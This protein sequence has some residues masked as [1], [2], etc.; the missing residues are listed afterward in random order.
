[1][2]TKSRERGYAEHHRTDDQ[3]SD[4][5]SS[6]YRKQRNEGRTEHRLEQFQE[7]LND[8]AAKGGNDTDFKMKVAEDFR[9]EKNVL[10]HPK[11]E[12]LKYMQTYVEAFNEV[13]HANFRERAK[14]AK[15]I[16]QN[17]FKPIYQE[18]EALEADNA[19]KIPE[20][21]KKLFKKEGITEF[22]YNEET[23]SIEFDFK[24]LKQLERVSKRSGREVK[25]LTTRDEST[26]SYSRETRGHQEDPEDDRNK[27]AAEHGTASLSEE[28]DQSLSDDKRRRRIETSMNDFKEGL[29]WSNQ[30]PE[31]NAE[32]MNNALD[33]ASQYANMP[34]REMDE[35][36]SFDAV[37]DQNEEQLEA[38]V[39]DKVQQNWSKIH[40]EID[41]TA[42]HNPEE[43]ESLRAMSDALQEA[44]KAQ[45][46]EGVQRQLLLPV[47]SISFA[48]SPPVLD[49][50]VEPR[51]CGSW[52][53]Q[54]PG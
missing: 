17:V 31:K 47:A 42:A 33:R 49:L 5:Q 44:H 4:E 32:R 30:N 16:T 9:D 48:G 40:E 6:N 29:L 51:Q 15:E 25:V 7:S 2:T 53:R 34:E 19:E 20:S 14:A 37:K 35:E 45:I 43:A 38:Q 50:A 28:E 46:I 36:T 22:R 24:D 39:T 41:R 13:D 18:F 11:E 26:S 12:R 3:T 10:E 23:K 8:T 1:M 27:N 54:T 52:A 21:V